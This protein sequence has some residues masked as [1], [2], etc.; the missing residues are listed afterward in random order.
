MRRRLLPL[1]LA[2]AHAAPSAAT[3]VGVEDANDSRGAEAVVIRGEAEASRLTGGA[4]KDRLDLPQAR[5]RASQRA[6]RS[7]R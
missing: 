1:S 5:P 2:I 7:W 4:G 3:T 6:A